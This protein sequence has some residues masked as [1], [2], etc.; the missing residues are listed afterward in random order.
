MWLA[1]DFAPGTYLAACFITDPETGMPH[2]M[3][4]MIQVIV[5]E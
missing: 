5:I 4:G 3:I 1:V 2:A